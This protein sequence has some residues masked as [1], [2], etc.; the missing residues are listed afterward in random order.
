M[1]SPTKH[2]KLFVH[3][4]PHCQNNEAAMEETKQGIEL[5]EHIMQLIEAQKRQILSHYSEFK[6]KTPASIKSATIAQ[7][8]SAGA[9][10]DPLYVCLPVRA[11]EDIHASTES[12]RKRDDVEDRM[13]QIKEEQTKKI[14]NYYEKLKKSLPPEVRTVQLKHLSERSIKLYT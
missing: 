4:T 6:L 10:I 5:R 9:K 11:I 7:L 1:F 3:D 13:M 14:K 12:S 8:R 2:N